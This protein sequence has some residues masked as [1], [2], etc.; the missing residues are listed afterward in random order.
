MPST[1]TCSLYQVRCHCTGVNG[2]QHIL[3]VTN[4]VFDIALC[5]V[6]RGLPPSPATT[7]GPPSGDVRAPSGF[8]RCANNSCQY[9]MIQHRVV[10]PINLYCI[11]PV[12]YL[13]CICNVFVLYVKYIRRVLKDDGCDFWSLFLVFRPCLAIFPSL[14]PVRMA[15]S[16]LSREASLDLFLAV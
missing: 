4:F 16:D 8:S 6:W 7:F 3:V 9:E 10:L 11:V 1:S 5:C 14:I 12:L 15:S 2:N 13:Y